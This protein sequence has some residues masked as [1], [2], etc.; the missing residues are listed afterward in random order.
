MTLD[1]TKDKAQ[2]S[3]P[4][5]A[6]QTS[7]DE[8]GSTSGGEPETF[9]KADLEKARSDALAEKGREVKEVSEKL[10]SV[11]TERDSLQQKL[12]DHKTIVDDLQKRID[13][14]E[15]Q[16]VG[17]DPDAKAALR[18]KKEAKRE[19]ESLVKKAREQL[20]EVTKR[21][22][23]AKADLDAANKAKLEVHISKL[24]TK[25]GVNED[26]LSGLNVSDPT[27]L[28]Q[29]AE[30]AGKRVEDSKT[31]KEP[32]KPDSGETLGGVGLPDK[33]KDKIKAGWA[34]LHK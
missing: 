28:E 29:I 27:I 25:Y 10:K 26:W 2:D 32:I 14:L 20:V 16:A 17:D 34:E 11:S 18:Q 1:E 31:K 12:D 5:E 22:E 8:K 3:P 9:T 24:S 6:G 7:G 33:A 19:A 30:K 13:D 4:P 21:E 15:L 23:Q